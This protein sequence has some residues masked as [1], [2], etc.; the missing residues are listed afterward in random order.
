MHA[1]YSLLQPVF[2]IA[3][4]SDLSR[5]V[6]YLAGVIVVSLMGWVVK[7]TRDVSRAITRL[8]DC[9][10]GYTG[11]NGLNRDVEVLREDVDKLLDRRSETGRRRDDRPVPR[12]D[13]P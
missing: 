11:T 3:G 13:L 12:E 8:T 4:D 6:L 7:V 5:A 10:F 1:F 9:L 2:T